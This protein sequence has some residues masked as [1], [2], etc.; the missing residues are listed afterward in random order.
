MTS[1]GPFSFGFLEEFG[2]PLKRFATGDVLFTAGSPGDTML[3]VLE[4]RVDVKLG[5][6]TVDT[7]GVYTILGEM[8]LIDAGPRSATAV[9]ASDGEMAIIDRQTFLD[10]VREQPSFSLY[11]MRAMATRL[12][13]MNADS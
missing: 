2:V 10:L 11:V 7:A 8:A 13:R 5:E 1:A 4:G 3:L 9:A 12:R 6:R